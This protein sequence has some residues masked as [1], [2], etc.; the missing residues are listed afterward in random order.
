MHKQPMF[1]QMQGAQ[2]THCFT[3]AIPHVTVKNTD[4]ATFSTRAFFVL[5]AHCCVKSAGW[6]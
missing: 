6:K 4:S 2:H 3:P 1:I 5:F